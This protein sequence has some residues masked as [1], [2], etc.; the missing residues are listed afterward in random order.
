MDGFTE[1]SYS[2]ATGTG[3]IQA[4]LYR[5]SANVDQSGILVQIIHGMAEHMQRYD[6][7]CRFLA[8]N[9]HFVSINDLP[10]HGLSAPSPEYLG[11]F[12]AEDGVNRILKDID[13]LAELVYETLADARLPRK[14]VILGHSM[15]SFISR[16]YCTRPGQPL[17]GAIFSGTSGSNPA[18]ALGYL[19]AKRAVRRRGPLYKDTFLSR[20]TSAGNLRRIANPRTSCDWLCRDG[21]IVDAYIADPWCGYIFTSAGYR[22]LFSW[23]RLV[24]RRDWP[25]RIVKG[26]RIL[27]VSGREDPIGQYGR[28]PRQV[29]GRLIKK[30][31]DATLI[32]YEE[33]RHEVLNEI[34][35]EEVWRDLAD[36]LKSLSSEPEAGE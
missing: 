4:R 11:Y 9:G 32:L 6:Q 23:L 13:R 35:R 31:H 16:H 33:A 1:L 28:G 34:N 24:S 2:S 36:W 29:C 26:L 7:F 22:D 14:R 21:K 18:A 25:D 17:A 30:G 3:T 12:G 5:P 27:L 20:L 19:L 10:G 8:D 15:G